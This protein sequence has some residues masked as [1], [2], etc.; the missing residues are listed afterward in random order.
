MKVLSKLNS[1]DNVNDGDTRK[2]ITKTSESGAGNVVSSISVSGDTVSYT[3]GVSALTSHQSA[4]SNVKV[5][6]STIAADQAGDILELAAGDNITLTPDTTN[7]KVTITATN[8]D[9]KVKQT[10][11]TSSNTAL[12]VLF[13]PNVLD[14]DYTGSVN[15][16]S[17][18]TYNPTTKALNTGGSINGY[19]LA[20]ASAKA[21]DSSITAAS[22]STNLPTSQAVATFVEGKGYV[23]TDTK[24]TAGSTDT[25][26]KIYLIGATS[27][28]ANP[29]TYSDNEVFVT[30]GVLQAKEY[31]INNGAKI[32]YNS[33][34]KTIEF[35]FI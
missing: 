34:D 14:T 10:V 15:K 32:V 1:L 12:R 29:Q 11:N 26:S 28:A 20:G 33:T 13:T 30:S 16:N 18:F 24:N 19:T 31:S 3:K 6:S 2:L 21:V 4:F 23:T 17:N 22:T 25:S 8:T 9:E 35:S 5:G 27:Q 7:D